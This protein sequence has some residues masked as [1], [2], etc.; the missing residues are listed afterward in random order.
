MNSYATPVF[1]P[2]VTIKT[3]TRPTTLA[4][5]METPDV[6]DNPLYQIL[7]SNESVDE[8]EK[9]FAA[10]LTFTS[11][12]EMEKRLE[13]IRELQAFLQAEREK[14]GVKLMSL[15]DTN[16]FAKMRDTYETMNNNYLLFEKEIA[17]LT[18]LLDA[19]YKLRMGGNT[20]QAFREISEF[21]KLEEE[22]LARRSELLVEMKSKGAQITAW[23]DDIRSEKKKRT[24][25]GLGSV[26]D[27]ASE[28]IR[29]LEQ[30]IAD[31]RAEFDALESELVDID[32]FLSSGMPAGEDAQ[33]LTP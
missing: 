24:W 20:T 31:A 22:K 5:E 28:R 14:L 23:V 18:A 4:N 13:E 9:A 26:T 11:K 17:P 10:A 25:F 32:K 1:K 2:K 19:V 29:E 30:C 33:S 3:E 16:V 15:T 7:A 21:K 8:K 6:K 12:K 27:A